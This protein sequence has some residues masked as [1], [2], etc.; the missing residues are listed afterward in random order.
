MHASPSADAVGW[1]S[2]PALPV[3]PGLEPLRS[4]ITSA[5]ACVVGLGG[6]GLAAVDELTTRGLR[7]VGVDAGRVAGAAA[8]RNGGILSPGGAMSF[9]EAC[10]RFGPPTA[11]DLW[12]RTADELDRLAEQLGEQVIRRD[13]VL[14]LAGLPGPPADD[15]EEQERARAETD[16]TRDHEI[17]R[18]HGLPAERYAGELGSGVFLP[19][20]A[21]MNPVARAFALAERLRNGARLHENTPVLSV[22]PGRVRTGFGIIRADTVVVAVDG[23]L[24]VL[25]PALRPHVRTQRLQMLATEPIARVRLPCPASARWGYDY[26]QQDRRGRLLVGGGRDRFL[27]EENTLDDRPTD[28]VQRRIEEITVRFAGGPVS[29]AHR[30]AASVGYTADRRAVCAMV[31]EGVVACGAYSGSGNLVGAV[32]ARAAV[33]L[34]LD[35]EPAPP[36]FIGRL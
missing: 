23:K 1:D 36:Y 11:W 19:R 25:L 4:P 17:M 29:V 32:A 20:G 13:G 10:S 12:Q 21:S 2:D 5:D 7:V 14:R 24:E 3:W 6:S 35:G 16:L 31:D 22:S 8:G 18:R 26:A 15:A 27:A 33:A 28:G 30:W 34:A 9:S